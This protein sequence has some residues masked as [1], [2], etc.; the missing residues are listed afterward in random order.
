[1]DL[2]NYGQ[3]NES[4]PHFK[5]PQKY[6][7]F[8]VHTLKILFRYQSSVTVALKQEMGLWGL[9]GFPVLWIRDLYNTTGFQVFFFCRFL[10]KG[11]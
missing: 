8:N 9:K 1:M 11:D 5:I 6:S 7:M 10:Q 2:K 4:V 3:M